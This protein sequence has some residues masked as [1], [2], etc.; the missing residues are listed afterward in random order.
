MDRMKKSRKIKAV[1]ASCI[2]LLVIAGIILGV[3]LYKPWFNGAWNG[4]FNAQECLRITKSGE[5]L[6][7][8]QITDLHVDHTN[9]QHDRIWKNLDALLQNNDFDLA[10]VTGDW[11]SDEE[12]IPPTEKL[13]EVMD[14][15]GKPWAVIFGNHDSEGKATREELADLF[16]K[17]KNCLFAKGPEELSGVGNYV[18]N[19]YDH[20]DS[21]HLDAALFLMDS[22]YAKAG[23]MDYRPLYRDQI[24]WYERNVDGLQQAYAGQ[25]GNGAQTL[26]SL[27]FIHVP[28]NEYADGWE[29]A[30]VA[31]ENHLHGSNNEDVYCPYINTGMFRAIEEKQSTKAVFA[32]HDHAN[33]SAVWYHDVLLA[34]GVQ[35]GVCET[36]PYASTM[37]KG[38]NLITLKDDGTVLVDQILTASYPT[39][40]GN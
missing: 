32:G 18:I 12:N 20:E 40:T 5:D 21:D 19:V 15:C 11:T 38:A 2:A 26:P 10:V 8:L 6:K 22:H 1:L 31:T 9:E 39:T 24:K 30:K 17:A 3:C 14:A 33:T 16:L 36:D 23:T 28:L 13:I 29:Q 7:V 35:T 4:D 34:Y 25:T 27:L 37:R